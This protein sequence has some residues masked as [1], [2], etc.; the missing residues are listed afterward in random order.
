MTDKVI[1]PTNWDCEP[2]IPTDAVHVRYIT[3]DFGSARG[4]VANVRFRQEIGLDASIAVANCLAAAH[5]MREALKHAEARIRRLSPPDYVAPEL[6]GIAAV[7]AKSTGKAKYLDLDL[8]QP[9]FASLLQAQVDLLEEALGRI[10]STKTESG[11]ADQ[12][13]TQ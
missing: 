6:A 12:S 7:I 3:A 5:D 9:L 1:S 13:R 2:P 10:A 4:I 8:T 11:T